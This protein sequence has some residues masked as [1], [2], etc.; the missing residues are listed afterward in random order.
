AS[1]E[2]SQQPEVDA[3]FFVSRAYEWY[4]ALGGG[5]AGW[6]DGAY[7]ASSVPA[8]LEVRVAT[9]VSPFN[10]VNG[11]FD[12]GFDSACRWIPF[13][14]LWDCDPRQSCAVLSDRGL[15]YFAGSCTIVG[16]EY[17]HGITAFSFQD[18]VGN[19]GI[20]YVDWTAAFHEGLS[21]AFGCLFSNAWTWGPEVSPVGLVIRNAAFPRDALAWQNQP[22]AFPCGLGAPTWDH[23]ADALVATDPYARGTVL[24]HCAFLTTMG[25]LHER[26]GRSPAYIPVPALDHET[27]GGLDFS[28]T[29]KVWYD[30]LKWKMQAYVTTTG[31]PNVDSGIFRALRD[32]C[33]ET[34]EDLYGTGSR[35][36]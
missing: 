7:P 5:R 27:H 32:G 16:H 2:D 12:K 21:D 9:H 19:P 34:A 29:A 36:Q 35:E 13:L 14:M 11:R 28:R 18:T 1:R 15:D 24:A 31:L 10:K 8:N 20:G 30:A 26:V 6:D 25:G 23:F 17:Q 4:D 3:H 33:V 22:G